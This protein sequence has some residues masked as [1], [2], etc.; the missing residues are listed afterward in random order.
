MTARRPSPAA[1][2]LL[3]G[4]LAAAC[5]APRP[6]PAAL[7]APTR[8]LPPL[9]DD[10][11]LASLRT[12]VERTLPVYRSAADA[13]AARRLLEILETASDARERRD[14]VLQAF[15]VVA[16]EEPVL[17]TAYYLPELAVRLAPDET[18][19]HPL[20]A[21]PPDLVDVDPGVFDPGCDCRRFAGRVE[22]GRLRPYPTRAEIDGGALAGRGLELAWAADPVGL[23]VLHV[24]GSGLL[25]FDDG[26]VVGVGY[27]G[28]N[29]RPYRSVGQTLAERGLLDAGHTTLPDIRRALA[30]VPPE[31]QARLLATNERYTFFRVGEGGVV[32]S[33]G[34]ELTAGRSIAADPRLVPLGAIAYLATPSLR[35]LVVSQDTGAAIVG[36][37][38]DLFLGAGAA[39][40]AVA[41]AM[42]DRGALF[43]LRPRAA[44]Y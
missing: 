16:F 44:S 3:A 36:A 15:D 30:S 43:V 27:A 6:R 40:E 12:A 20:Y 41:G 31:E 14:T 38:A 29:G 39:A 35:R 32:G 37:R 2:L 9:E 10:L 13:A 8:D 25:R 11:D 4:G 42:R 24:Q 26:R 21:R 34:V 17:L 23:F 18:F 33:L 5:A 7:V 22:G 28:S 1:L 19:R